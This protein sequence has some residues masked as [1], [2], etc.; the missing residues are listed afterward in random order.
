MSEEKKAKELELKRRALLR[1]A[2][3]MNM[4]GQLDPEKV[5][6]INRISRQS[7]DAIR[8]RAMKEIEE[9]E[10]QVDERLGPSRMKGKGFTEKIGGKEAQKVIPGKEFTESIAKK[11]A[12]RKIMGRG[13][14]ALPLVGGLASALSSGE[15]SAAIPVLG[16]ADDLGPE[17]GSPSAVIEDPNST[18]EERMRAIQMLRGRR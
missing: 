7:K 15:A 12:L 14:K 5:E 6:A 18:I 16:E 2:R 13:M 1:R 17:A 10:I 3:Q 9:G 8:D 11:R 4:E